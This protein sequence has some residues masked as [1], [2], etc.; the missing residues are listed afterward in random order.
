MTNFTRG[1]VVWVNLDP[2]IGAEIKKRRPCV[3]MSLT[4]TN[5]VRRNVVVVPL[6]SSGTPRPPF[7]VATPSAGPTS[8]AR[9]DQVRTV[10]KSR[11]GGVVCSLSLAEMFDIRKA[12][13]TV[14]GL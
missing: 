8:N 11:I 3:I 6:A 1:D 14:L 12:I 10:D 7:V 2:A 13:V 5:K 9:I 4:A